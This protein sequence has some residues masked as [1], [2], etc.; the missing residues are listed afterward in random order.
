MNILFVSQCSKRAL[1]ETRRVLDQFAERKGDRTWQT[2]VTA[3]GLKT[4]RQM[5]RK[6]A[7]RNTAVACHWLKNNHQTELLWTVGNIR[8]F[9]EQGTVPT[10]TTARNILRSEDESYWQTGEA[11]ALMAG[12]AGLFHD[13]G[14]ANEMFQA[15]LKSKSSEPKSEPVRHEWVS[16]RLFQAFVGDLD[17]RQWLEKLAT[18]SP[19]HDQ[20][21][22]AALKD[23]QLR[24]GLDREQGSNPF[25]YFAEPKK[26]QKKRYRPLAQAI[27]WLIVSHHRL[28]QFYKN[29]DRNIS[30]QDY[31]SL[32]TSNQLGPLCNSPQFKYRNSQELDGVWNI[33]H[34]PLASKTW[35]AKAQ[36]MAQRAGRLSQLWQTDWMSQ[37][38]SMHVARLSLMLADHYYSALPPAESPQTWRDNK[39]KLL[40]NTDRKT[41][42]A[43]QRLDEHNIGV[44]HHGFLFAKSLPRLQLNLPTI[45]RLKGLRERVKRSDAT[46]YFLW[47][48]AAYDMACNLAD[49]SRQQ[50]FFGVNMASTGRGKTLANAKIMYGLAGEQGAR[51]SVALG[52]RTLT[53]QTG[54]A[55]RERLKLCDEDLAV[56]VGSA[57]VRSLY[58][59]SQ[60]DAQSD[61]F[62]TGSESEEDSFAEHEYVRYEGSQVDGRLRAWLN[63]GKDKADSKLSKLLS[64]PVV[65][66]TIDHLTPATEGCRGGKQIAPMLRLLTS[67]LILDEPDDFA[68]ED[69]PALCRLVHWSGMLGSRVLL[70]SATLPPDFIQALFQAYEKGRQAYR[71]AVSG[72]E[73]ES[74][75]CAWVDE[76]RSHSE[77]V[78]GG[79]SFAAQ[80]DWFVDHRVERL[81]KQTDITQRADLLEV[82]PETELCG[83]VLS[84]SIDLHHCHAERSPCGR[85]VSFGLIRLA[86]I[87]HIGKLAQDLIKQKVPDDMQIHLCVYHSR[88]PLIVR[89]E[90]ERQLDVILSRGDDQ[91]IWQQAAVQNALKTSR[92]KHHL[93][94]VLASPVA[95]V[96]RDHDYSWAIVEPSS[97]RAI[98]QLAGRVQRHRRQ[99][100][101]QANILIWQ[102]NIRALN[103]LRPAYCRPGF[104]TKDLMLHEHDLHNILLPEQYQIPSA[105]SR[106]KPRELF[107]PNCNLVD[108]EHAQIKNTLFN[109]DKNSK[110]AADLFW[111]RNIHWS[112]EVQAHTRFRQSLP[113]I[114]YC[115]LGDAE[116]WG[117]YNLSDYQ[118]P[119]LDSLE[120]I[121]IPSNPQVSAW[122][123][124]DVFGLCEAKAEREGRE[125]SEIQKQFACFSV[126][127]GS[128][129]STQRPHYHP[130]L[131]VF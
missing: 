16:L 75:A 3:E 1:Q 123:V 115:L 40:A 90:I 5:L 125:L 72:H 38:F 33:A 96:G 92:A 52:L 128:K 122:L 15:K 29:C 85:E 44:G 108:L 14:K 41:K 121:E 10:N 55:F 99:L 36:R 70:S 66:C 56:L 100:V 54:D 89:A 58:G 74:I 30:P 51:F 118:A 68:H 93:F 9:N 7:R 78:V 32:L 21:V 67:D 45:G 120:R 20:E 101:S 71:Q 106:I 53:L 69:L 11:I 79:E 28:P 17:D 59:D 109:S 80:H 76:F 91:A 37:R 6:R 47:Q 81:A 87:K 117:F 83:Q 119:K 39:F 102:K 2:P 22:L 73:N 65:V 24:D 18:V 60:Q 111:E 31:D 95:E 86:N 104:E 88:H 94:L 62:K 84:A 82:G 105:I 130:W 107:E 8:R 61:F 64:A 127:E 116:D 34:T 23:N 42:K 63:Q 103:G 124:A 25:F 110:V 112:G 12:L 97:M 13:V 126:P 77:F 50:G 98:I 46:R 57:A 48:N 113:D 43:K 35:C 49:Q 26:G 4:V 131:G 129:N 19:N 114:D 27:G